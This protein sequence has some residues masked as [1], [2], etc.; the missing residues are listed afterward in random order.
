MIEFVAASSRT[1]L[2][3]DPADIE[4][5]SVFELVGGPGRETLRI[6]LTAEESLAAVAFIDYL[7][8]R[9]PGGAIRHFEAT[10]C[11]LLDEASVKGIALTFHDVTERERSVDELR[12]AGRIAD[13]ANRM[14]TEFIANMSHELRTPLNAVLGFSEI[15]AND[16][17]NALSREKCREYAADVHRSATHLLAIINDILDLSKAEAESLALSEG[18]IDVG[19]L[20]AGAVRLV[21]PAAIDKRVRLESAIASG[22]PALRGDERRLRQVLVNLLSNAVK[23]SR[24]GGRVIIRAGLSLTG[25]FEFDVEDFGIGIPEDK[26]TH[27][28]DP[29]YQVDGSLARRHEG[30]GLGLAIARSLAELHG[31]RLL[32]SSEAGQGTVA[33]LVLPAD[34]VMIVAAA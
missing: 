26:L 15:I 20:V 29:F 27:V 31:G 3:C 12:R 30:T 7:E 9:D 11:N 18:S 25:D 10:A 13:E 14:K 23:F 24:Q 16:A 1:V 21:G 5:R 19:H 34:R 4:R 2:G 17:A 6:V 22:V 28:F 33:R 8:I 32:L